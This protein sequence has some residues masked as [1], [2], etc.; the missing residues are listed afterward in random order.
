M[1]QDLV[2]VIIVSY[3]ARD[4]L[5]NCLASIYRARM[6][7]PFEVIVVDNA[8]TDGS[9]QMVETMFPEA[10]LIENERNLGFAKANNRGMRISRGRYLLLLN[11]DTELEP[12]VVEQL[13][14]FMEANAGVGAVAPKLLNTDGSVQPSANLSFPGLLAFVA[15][16]LFF[17]FKLQQWF[18]N[19]RFFSA[20]ILKKY[21]LKFSRVQKVAWVGWAAVLLRREAIFEIGL[22]DENYFLYLEDLDC[23]KEFVD[24]GW[25]VYYQPQVAVTH[26]W[27][28]SIGQEASLAFTALQQSIK[29]Y[30]HKHMGPLAV[31]T[32][33]LSLFAELAVRIMLC[34]LAMIF[35]HPRGRWFRKAS[36]FV[37]SLREVFSPV[38]YRRMPTKRVVIDAKAMS[39]FS[40]GIGVY[41]EA[42]L[43]R[44]CSDDSLSIEIVTDKRIPAGRLGSGVRQHVI[45]KGTSQVI[46]THWYLRRRLKRIKPDVYHATDPFDVPV[47]PGYRCMT[48]VQDVRPLL[49]E[50]FFRHFGEKIYYRLS[51]KLAI[52]HSC[53]IVC[54]SQYAKQTLLRFFPTRPEKIRIIHHGIDF[55]RRNPGNTLPV[56]D[57]LPQ[58]VAGNY[59]V[60]LGPLVALKNQINALLGVFEFNRR[61]GVGLTLVQAGEMSP[62]GLSLKQKAT[63]I[64]MGDRLIFLGHLAE[65]EVVDVISGA[66]AMLFLSLEEGFGFPALESMACG[67]PLIASNRSC[68]PEIVKEGGILVDPLNPSE[69]ADALESVIYHADF[70][71]ALIERGYR[72]VAGYTWETSVAG[73]LDIYRDILSETQT[74]QNLANGDMPCR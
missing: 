71:K 44:L 70:R 40:G 33:R 2:S 62:Y 55:C 17:R 32:I 9:L 66:Q 49:I 68:L 56:T 21:S 36:L 29:I 41:V 42:L 63:E 8:S 61:Y 57:R 46:W 30:L 60:C 4:V 10:V 28:R 5:R 1:K 20:Y 52:C 50:G 13:V 19:S 26:H 7:I 73:H 6:T 35:A 69:I 15:D 38:N 24:A 3:N 53:R 23:C 11:S 72:T 74:L 59:V 39:A 37:A 54:P 27:N 65:Q 64:G 48:T 34:S 31:F 14:A 43:R 16:K 67:T 51:H 58:Q 25:A 45:P 47:M 22:M 12:G 18:L